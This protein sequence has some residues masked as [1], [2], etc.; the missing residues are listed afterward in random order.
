MKIDL[1]WKKIIHRNEVNVHSHSTWEIIFVNEGSGVLVVDEKE[2]FFR[3]N[4]IICIPPNMIRYN[5]LNTRNNHTVILTSDFINVPEDKI[6]IFEDN[7]GKTIH[8][9]FEVVISEFYSDNTLK[10]EILSR[11]ED[12]LS[13]LI[14]DM[15]YK[16]YKFSAVEMVKNAMITNFANPDF[17]IGEALKNTN[18]SEAHFR[19]LFNK[20]VGMSPIK[21]LLELRLNSAATQL[22]KRTGTGMSVA[23]VASESGFNDQGYFTRKFKEKYGLTPR[24]YYSKDS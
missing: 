1:I 6:L 15:I 23:S 3:E 5:K 21:Y 4:N 10:D 12:L 24:E 18:Y 20:E 9:L 14:K 11:L 17:T 8:N 2:Y 7:S 19:K 13:I 16:G 22:K